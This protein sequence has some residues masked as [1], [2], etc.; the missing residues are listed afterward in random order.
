METKTCW[1]CRK[2]K[3]FDDFPVWGHN[4]RRRAK[5]YDCGAREGEDRF[6]TEYAAALKNGKLV[7]PKR[8]ERCG[9]QRGKKIVGHHESYG[10]GE[11]LNV[12]WLCTN[13]HAKVHADKKKEKKRQFELLE[14]LFL[15]KFMQVL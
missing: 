4:G 9:K 2:E 10:P 5:C 3:P 11:A 15:P 14:P 7:K 12:T 13:C 1:V 8:C 6:R